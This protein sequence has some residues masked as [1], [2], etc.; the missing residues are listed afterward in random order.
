MQ[1]TD[2]RG[3]NKRQ[4]KPNEQSVTENPETNKKQTTQHRKQKSL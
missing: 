2:K 3:V 1:K 4:R